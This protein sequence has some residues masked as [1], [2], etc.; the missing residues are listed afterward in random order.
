MLVCLARL[1]GECGQRPTIKENL[2]W[3]ASL[4][5]HRLHGNHF[6]QTH[7]EDHFTQY[8]I[9]NAIANSHSR[10]TISDSDLADGQIQIIF[11]QQ[12]VC[13]LLGHEKEVGEGVCW[14]DVSILQVMGV[15]ILLEMTMCGTVRALNFFNV[16]HE[17]T[18]LV[19]IDC[20]GCHQPSR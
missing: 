3:G 6:K 8:K 2:S 4:F 18:F 12:L 14:F 19:L 15:P 13:K 1:S 5:G 16:F 11:Q 10:W 9:V 17:D 20:I 7:G